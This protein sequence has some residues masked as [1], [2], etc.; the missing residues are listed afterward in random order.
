VNFT[1]KGKGKRRGKSKGKGKGKGH[2]GDGRYGTPKCYKRGRSG[3]SEKTVMRKTNAKGAEIG[4]KGKSNENTNKKE[5][6]NKGFGPKGKVVNNAEENAVEEESN[7]VATVNIT[8]LGGQVVYETE[9]LE[10]YG[11]LDA[12]FNGSALCSRRRLNSYIKYLARK[13]K[14]VVEYLARQR[15]YPLEF[16]FGAGEARESREIIYLPIWRSE[17][18]WKFVVVLF[19]AAPS[20]CWEIG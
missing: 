7:K 13:D 5:N 3:H 10:F 20:C 12:G 14:E 17:E 4:E 9:G 11:A 19:Q 15:A 1:R 16:A 6:G 18:F 8:H 2:M